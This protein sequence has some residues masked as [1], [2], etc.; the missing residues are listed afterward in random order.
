MKNRFKIVRK[1]TT[2]S[3]KRKYNLQPEKEIILMIE[4]HKNK[5]KI[6]IP[7]KNYDVIREKRETFFL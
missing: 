5:K 3:P 2:K 4:Y 7:L 1:D 6:F